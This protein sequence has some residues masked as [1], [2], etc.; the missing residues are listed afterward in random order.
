MSFTAATADKAG[1]RKTKALLAAMLAAEPQGIPGGTSG[2]RVISLPA[3]VRWPQL[4]A[5][6]LFVRHFYEDCY[7]HVMGRL[8]PGKHFIVRGTGGGESRCTLFGR[9]PGVCS[10]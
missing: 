5:V 4:G 3:G 9:C 8:E 10:C 6:P 7:E 2:A 1:D